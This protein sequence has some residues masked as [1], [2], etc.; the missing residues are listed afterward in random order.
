[1]H[2]R[3]LQSFVRDW[4]ES[5]TNV[6]N[7]SDRSIAPDLSLSPFGKEQLDHVLPGGGWVVVQQGGDYLLLVGMRPYALS[8][9][10]DRAFEIVQYTPLYGVQQS[11]WSRIGLGEWIPKHGQ[12]RS[13][14]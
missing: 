6:F 3:L 9:E 10:G 4:L 13:F 14:F 7:R 1:M 2:E 5:S 11:V 8:E 12:Y